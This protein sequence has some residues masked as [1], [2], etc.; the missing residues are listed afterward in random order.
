MDDKPRPPRS[1][2]RRKQ[3]SGGLR[4][5]LPSL[6]PPS[7]DAWAAPEKGSPAAVTPPSSKAETP[8]TRDE[9]VAR[10]EAQAGSPPIELPSAAP[11]PA[12]TERATAKDPLS[13]DLAEALKSVP[14]VKPAAPAR[15]HRHPLLRIVFLF[16]LSAFRLIATTALVFA[17][18]GGVSY[19]ILK[20]YVRTFETTVPLIRNVPVEEALDKVTAAHLVMQLDRREYSENVARGRIVEQFPASGVKV[21]AGTPVRVIVSDGAVQVR[22]PKLVGLSEINAGVA[23]RSVAQAD[24]DIAELDRA[25]SS[26]VKKGD[27]IGQAPPAGRADCSWQQDQDPRQSRTAARGLQHAGFAQQND[28][29][30]PR[31]PGKNGS[32]S[33]SIARKRPSRSGTRH[34]H[35]SRARSGPAHRA[36][37]G[38]LAHGRRGAVNCDYA[39]AAQV[40]VRN[41]QRCVSLGQM[42]TARK[43]S[44]AR[45]TPMGDTSNVIEIRQTE[46]YSQWFERLHDRHARARILVRIRRLSLGDFGDVKPV[47]EGV[48]ELRIAFGP[49]YR[50]YFKQ[51]G[52]ALVVLLAGGDKRTQDRDI[53]RAKI[54]ARDI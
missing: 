21:K 54:L 50:V 29:G 10:D 14:P 13:A 37:L 15:R 43:I 5:G 7:E 3:G 4:D 11:P 40:A 46:E 36:G 33:R 42:Q 25:Y 6:I 48:S 17:L 32:Q 49:G 23:V 18:V 8:M 26:T 20:R 35:R 47:G 52:D 31:R 30:G 9:S 44:L 38:G 41:A 28:P 22:A 1:S 34:R 12:G 24:L 16:F 39:I 2:K 53:A 19:L 51:Q 27:V 45:T